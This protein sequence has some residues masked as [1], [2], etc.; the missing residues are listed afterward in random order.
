MVRVWLRDGSQHMD[1]PGGLEQAQGPNDDFLCKDGK[2]GYNT[3]NGCGSV[4]CGGS[5]R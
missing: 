3:V 5:E 4:L 2:G 1:C